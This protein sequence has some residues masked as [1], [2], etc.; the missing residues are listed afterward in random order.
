M[1]NC[2]PNHWVLPCVYRA[3]EPQ[4]ISHIHELKENL[5]IKK[6]EEAKLDEQISACREQLQQIVEN[7]EN[8]R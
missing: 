4:E 3:S 8:W 1:V 5:E 6:D 2:Y 7:Q